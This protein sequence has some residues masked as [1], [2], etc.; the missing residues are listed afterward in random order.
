MVQ[1]FDNI[2]AIANLSSIYYL[3]EE[4]NDCL[5]QKLWSFFYLQVIGHFYA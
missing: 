1:P 2:W 5:G 4:V 3:K